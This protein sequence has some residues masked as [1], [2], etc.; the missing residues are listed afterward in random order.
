M[1]QARIA[2]A[3]AG[4]A[5][6]GR[7]LA[8][9]LRAARRAEARRLRS[10]SSRSPTSARWRVRSPARSAASRASATRSVQLVMPQD[11]LFADEATPATAAVMLGNS[12][13]TLAP[14]AV[15]GMA[16]LVASSR[17][18]PE[19][20]RTSRSPTRP[21]RILWPSGD[22]RRRGGRRRGK[23]ARR[24]ALRP[25]DGGRRSTRC[26][27]RTLGPGKAQVKV[28]ADLNVDKTTRRGADVRQEGRAADRRTTESEKLKGGGATTRRHGRHRLQHPDL[29]G[30]ARR[31][32]RGE[33]ATTSARTARPT[34]ASTRRS[35]T[36]KVAAGARQQA[37]R[38]AAGRQ[39]GPGRRLR[40]A[41]ADG[42]H[43]PPASTRRA[44]TRSPPRRWRSPSRRRPRPARSRRRCSARSSGS[45]SASPPA[46]PVLHDPRRCSKREGENLG[47]PAW[48]TDDRGAGLARRSSRRARQA[49]TST[50]ASDHDAARRACRTPACTSS[51]S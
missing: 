49:C 51:T 37:Q 5:G 8:A 41:Q 29:L 15:R 46:L 32:R 9:G 27:P 43:A 30:R 1:A 20:R 31:R 12:A 11:D 42:R 21:A 40:L 45:A 28:N 17:Q 4:R 19:D 47:T 6:L 34:T 16:Q 33:L 35:P 38:R 50:S 48:L 24:G 25:P 23:Q 44:A 39:V 2:L 18:G 22:G 26:S 14:G 36:P 7:R 10:S 3:G 13:D